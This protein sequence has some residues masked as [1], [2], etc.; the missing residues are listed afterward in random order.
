MIYPNSLVA[1]DDKAYFDIIFNFEFYNDFV[2]IKMNN[3]QIKTEINLISIKKAIYKLTDANLDFGILTGV[4]PTKIGIKCSSY[5][6]ISDI[7][8]VDT[9]K[10]KIIKQCA[11]VEKKLIDTIP[12]KSI[13]LYINIPFC[14]TRCKYCS[15]TIGGIKD[16]K[17][18]VDDYFKALIFDLEETLAILDELDI[19]VYSV[20]IGGGTPT[21]LDIKYLDILTNIITKKCANL[22]EFTV[23]AGRPDTISSENLKILK[24]N[25]VTRISINPQSLNQSTLDLAGRRHSVSQFYNAY[26]N[27]IQAGFKNINCD[28]IAGFENEQ[29]SDFKYTIDELIK[30]SPENLTVHTMCQKKN[31]QN[32]IENVPI[33]N[34]EVKKMLEY[35]Y[36]ITKNKYEPYYI[37]RQKN[38]IGSLENIGFSKK[39]AICVY[40]IIMMEEIATVVSVGAG[41]VSKLVGFADKKPFLRLRCDKQPETYISDIKNIF[42][43]KRK[44]LYEGHNFI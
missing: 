42:N 10:A 31:S 14:P 25:S 20:Y 40:N 4:R 15:F 24:N 27:A 35:S 6:D 32:Y 22:K 41:G 18:I 7:Y 8:L 34:D 28:I 30:L 44:F 3:N 33:F 39:N 17:L 11:D 43:K 5:E 2:I 19:C 1:R 12:K 29:F 37:Y 21:V 26:S 16:Y 36:E 38:A 13:A 23:E 9:K